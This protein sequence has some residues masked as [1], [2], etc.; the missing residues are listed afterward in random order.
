MALEPDD[1]RH[2]AQIIAGT[3]GRQ[4]GH[5]FEKRLAEDLVL[6]DPRSITIPSRPGHLITGDPA[7]ELVRYVAAHQG[8][9]HIDQVIGQWVG[10]LATARAGATIIDPAGKALTASKSDVL[11]GIES[12]N[13]NTQQG[14]SVKVCSNRTPTNAQLYFTTALGFCALLERHGIAMTSSARDG[15][16]MFCGDP[17]FRPADEPASLSGRVSDPDRWFFEELPGDARDDLESLLGENQDAITRIL[18]QQ[19]YPADPFPPEYLMH[20]RF[21]ADAEDR[22][23]L[24]IFSIDELV[25][26][27]ARAGAFSTRA[28]R[29][30]KGRFKADPADHLAPRFGFVQMQRGGQRQHPTQ[31]QFNLQAAYFTKVQP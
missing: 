21:R 4:R 3:T 18:L 13:T 8:L 26:Y 25:D 29:I 19:A 16:R 28:Y 7:L 5:G 11:L 2:A 30:R 12:R 20:Q 9:T 1:D 6:L 23:P 24:A 27:S 22:V 17:G 14:V 31:L 15:L 10:G